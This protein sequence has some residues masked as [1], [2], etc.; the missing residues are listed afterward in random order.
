MHYLSEV[1]TDC[2][3]RSAHD[4]E[5][6]HQRARREGNRLH[7]RHDRGDQPRRA[8]VGPQERRRRRRDRSSPR[9]SITRTSFRGRC[10]ARKRARTLRIAP[11]NDAGEVILD[12]FEKLLN[13]AHEDRR[14][15][16]RLERPRHDQSDPQD[17]RARAR[18]RRD[19]A[20]RRRA[21]R[22]ASARRRA[23]IST[24][25][26]T[27]SPAHKVYGPTGIGVLYGKEALLDAMPPWQGGGDMI[28]SV[29]FEKTTYNALPYKFEAGTPNIE[30]VIG[31]AA[32]LDYVSAIGIDAIAAHEQDLLALR[33]EAPARNR[34]PAHHRHRARRRPASS[35]SCSKASTRT[36]SARS[37]I[38]KGIAIRTGHHCAQP[39]MLR[40]N[41]PAT[42]RASFAHV[43][44]ARRGRR[45]RGRP[46]QSDRGVP[47]AMSDLRELY[48]QVILD[49]N[50]NPRNFHELPNATRSV[51]GYNPL[52]GDHYKILRGGRRRHDQRHRLHRQRLRDLES[53][54]VGDEL[55][56]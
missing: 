8:V 54:G 21:G 24:A 19:R 6:L 13:A 2:V 41:V 5:A 56:R 12:E 35:P 50:K 42:G 34:R 29:S 52:C 33:H 25:T 28:L 20:H 39:L 17:D 49:H 31:L 26:S 55:D 51:D 44:H 1:A 16:P 10:S 3:R 22:A 53:V 45:A 38:R 37:S 18:R 27:R 7:A 40:F 47:I 46:A 4:G 23:A 9:S 30:G 48:Q 43:Q 11:V 14:L 32:A 15:R 36:T